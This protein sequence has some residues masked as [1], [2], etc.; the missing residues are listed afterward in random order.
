MRSVALA[1]IAV[2]EAREKNNVIYERFMPLV[3][4]IG[5][6]LKVWELHFAGMKAAIDAG[7]EPYSRCLSVMASAFSPRGIAVPDPVYPDDD[8]RWPDTC[9]P[10]AK[11]LREAIRLAKEGPQL[12][13]DRFSQPQDSSRNVEEILLK[14][15]EFDGLFR[16][17]EFLNT[18]IITRHPPY[19]VEK[20]MGEFPQEM[21]EHWTT[22]IRIYLDRKY[23]LVT[24]KTREVED[25][26]VFVANKDRFNSAAEYF[27]S[28]EWDGV[29]RINRFFVDGFGAPSTP[30]ICAFGCKFLISVVRRARH[31]GAKVD[32]VPILKG[33][34]GTYKSMGIQALVP[35]QKWHLESLNDLNIRG[36]HQ[37]AGKLIVELPELSKI[38]TAETEHVKE[39]LSRTSDNYRAPWDRRPKDH[40]RQ[41]VFFG[42]TNEEFFLTDQTGN[43]RYWIIEVTKGNIEWIKENLEQLWAEAAARENRGEDHWLSPELEAEARHLQEAHRQEDPWEDLIPR[44]IKGHTSIIGTVI[45]SALGVDTSK[46]NPYYSNRVGRIMKMLGWKSKQERQPV[47]KGGGK[48]RIWRPHTAEAIELSKA[49]MDPD[50]EEM[51]TEVSD[52]MKNARPT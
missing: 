21:P 24:S 48:P 20:D 7:H 37:L 49:Q 31:P 5:P 45:L 32:T 35:F 29:H 1:T 22:G 51:V 42:S 30:L 46:K 25:A 18:V 27:D 38:K 17:D 33:E 23:G 44:I 36:Q 28:L 43:R 16:F 8:G 12:T 34:Q 50:F 15:R 26:I 9:E 14:D 52:E 47:S 19:I 4:T 2:D 6:F 40:P 10:F 11:E 3:G 41:C 39:W 13:I